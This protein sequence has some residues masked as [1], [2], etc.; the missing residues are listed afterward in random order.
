MLD[1]EQ[2]FTRADSAW[3][4][5]GPD[6]DVVI[7]TRIRLARNLADLPFPSRASDEELEQALV[8]LKS[9]SEYLPEAKR[10]RLLEMGRLSPLEHQVLIEKHLVSREHVQNPKKRALVLRDDEAVSIMINEED[11]ERLQVLLPGLNL[12]QAWQLANRLDDSLERRL[13]YAFDDELGFLTCCP[14]NL[15]SGLRAS[16]MLHL[17]ALVLSKQANQVLGTLAQFGLVI[18]GLY[19][20]ERRRWELFPGFKS[21]DLKPV[22]RGFNSQ[23]TCSYQSSY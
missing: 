14:T 8:R 15:G 6:G 5:E 2:I 19:G 3:L 10:Y 21:V 1:P 16:V 20:E 23:P 12:D 11:H 9:A 7:S 17:P 22:G 13:E 4:N 18:R